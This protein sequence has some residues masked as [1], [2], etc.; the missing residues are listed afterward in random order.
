MSQCC[1][2]FQNIFSYSRD[3][4]SRIV[5][6]NFFT[7]KIC[8]TLPTKWFCAK[9]TYTKFTYH[10]SEERSALRFSRLPKSNPFQC[11]LSLSIHVSSWL[12]FF[13]YL[14]QHR[15]FRYVSSHFKDF[16]R[17]IKLPK[18]AR[19]SP[20]LRIHLQKTKE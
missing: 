12:F 18:L 11:C 13:F 14:Y 17:V 8:V 20:F 16:L 4:R 10:I 2:V 5:I 7:D 6:R 19:Q 9:T 15:S 1:G 3:L